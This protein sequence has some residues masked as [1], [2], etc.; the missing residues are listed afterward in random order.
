MGGWGGGGVRKASPMDSDLLGFSSFSGQFLWVCESGSLLSFP[1]HFSYSKDLMYVHLVQ[2]IGEQIR[3]LFY[4]HIRYEKHFIAGMVWALANQKKITMINE[5][6]HKPQIE[7]PHN[8]L[9]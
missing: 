8:E 1:S 6:D 7:W 3:S 4:R 2:F 5:N 9:S